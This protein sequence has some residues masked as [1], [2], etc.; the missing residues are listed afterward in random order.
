MY[1]NEILEEIWAIKDQLWDEAG[2]DIH[3]FGQNLRAWSKANMPPPTAS[4]LFDPE[5]FWKLHDENARRA[6]EAVAEDPAIYGEADGSAPKN[7]E[8]P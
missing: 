2:G 7:P 6:A 1:S 8:Q 3:V 4:G 5:A